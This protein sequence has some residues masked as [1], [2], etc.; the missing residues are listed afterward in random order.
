MEG[1]YVGAE[2][3][4]RC[5]TTHVLSTLESRDVG[6]PDH[7]Y[8]LGG[9]AIHRT[10]LGAPHNS[11][12]TNISGFRAIFSVG[13]PSPSF[14]E[15]EHCFPV[16]AKSLVHCVVGGTLSFGNDSLTIS[17]RDGTCNI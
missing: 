1:N 13:D 14:R 4:Q 5:E 10:V 11:Q 7:L 16:M 2:M 12:A 9:F 15:A 3:Y 6:V 17:N 8:N